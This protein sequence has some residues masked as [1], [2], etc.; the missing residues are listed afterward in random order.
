M[1][2]NRRKREV[3]T[4]DAESLEPVVLH[5]LRNKKEVASR[6]QFIKKAITFYHEFLQYNKGFKIRLVQENFEEFRKIVRDIGR[7]NAEVLK[8]ENDLQNKI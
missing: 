5:L 8:R 1:Q 6:S 2:K 4:F 3:I 7:A